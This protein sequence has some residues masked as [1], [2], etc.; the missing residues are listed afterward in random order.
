ML[1]TTLQMVEKI[2]VT[3]MSPKYPVVIRISR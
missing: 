2:V 3:K 1:Y